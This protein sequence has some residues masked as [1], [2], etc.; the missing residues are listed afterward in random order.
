MERR[1]QKIIYIVLACLILI[2]LLRS[3]SV[4]PI[5]QIMSSEEKIV[6]KDQWKVK[7][8]KTTEGRCSEYF[9]RIPEDMS[10]ETVLSVKSY[11]VSIEVFVDGEE[12]YFQREIGGE[13]G[14]CWKWIELPKGTGGRLLSLRITCEKAVENSFV[15]S[16]VLLG[17]QNTV[18][19]KILEEEAFALIG[20]GITLLIGLGVWLGAA[21]LR[22][23]LITDEWK[24]A[25]NLGLFITI[26]G[27]WIVTDSDI[28]Q[29]YTDKLAF[30]TLVSYVCLMLMP[31]F[32]IQFIRKMMI[33]RTRGVSIMAQVHLLNSAI[34]MLL[35]I[36]RLVSLR[37]TLV[38][39]HI[40]IAISV[41]VVLK[42]GIEEVNRHKNREM[43]MILVGVVNLVLF[44]GIALV[45][46]YMNLELPYASFYGVGIFAFEFFLI[47]ATF[48]RVCYYFNRSAR[49]AKYQEIAYTDIM[50]QMGNRL[51]FT[52]QQE[53]G[54]WQEN[55]AYVVLDINNLKKA[56]DHHGHLKGDSLI[57]DAGKC[58]QEAFAEIGSCYRI[59]G[60]EFAVILHTMIEDEIRAAIAELHRILERANMNR[61]VPIEI[62]YGY[63][64]RRDV[65]DSNQEL[66]DEADANMYRKKIEMKTKS[67]TPK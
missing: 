55:R 50:T 34:C 58:I 28:L 39:T 44:G 46:F 61:E 59:G 62:A 31:Y 5:T 40:L 22:R 11:G 18:F 9:C 66:F 8:I 52:K 51:A 43:E 42:E 47:V 10:D 12:I 49:V 38:T 60:D 29:F 37:Q 20:G 35:Y 1:I 27:L 54:K 41:V 32:L 3:F 13:S 16:R 48:N 65:T 21:L 25:Y 6:H 45:M 19:L 23:R 57:V 2:A 26:A 7:Q 53:N 14:F 24:G 4:P 67:T 15:P 63:S 17:E 33:Y 64:I 56:N 36:L 30:G